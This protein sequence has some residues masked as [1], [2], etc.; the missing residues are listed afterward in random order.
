MRRSVPEAAEMTQGPDRGIRALL[1]SRE[2]IGGRADSVLVQDI[3]DRCLK[4]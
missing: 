2:D 1:M 4:T 3:G